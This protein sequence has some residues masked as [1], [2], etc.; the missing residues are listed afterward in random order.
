M[1]KPVI[2]THCGSTTHD[3]R[4]CRD[5]SSFST[6]GKEMAVMDSKVAGPMVRC[7]SCNMFGHV[8]CQSLPPVPAASAGLVLAHLFLLFPFL[9]YFEK[10]YE[11][12]YFLRFVAVIYFHGF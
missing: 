4:N 3:A 10:G 8:M 1:A 9:L 12:S 2:C 6:S 5:L 7:M 11:A